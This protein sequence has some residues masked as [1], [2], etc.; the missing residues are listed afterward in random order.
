M[1]RKGVVRSHQHPD[2]F[3]KSSWYLSWGLFLPQWGRKV[4]LAFCSC[5]FASQSAALPAAPPRS[6]TASPLLPFPWPQG[7]VPCRHSLGLSA[8]FPRG[9][10]RAEAQSGRAMGT[11]SLGAAETAQPRASPGQ[12]DH[13]QGLAQPPP[14]LSNSNTIGTEQWCALVLCYKLDLGINW[15]IY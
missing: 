8:A 15:F 10:H 9:T 12:H 14:C 5:T 6:P 11:G 2:V 4:P 13:S 1:E 7:C 3:I